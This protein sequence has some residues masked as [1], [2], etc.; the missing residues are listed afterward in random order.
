MSDHHIHRPI[1]LVVFFVIVV[2][3]NITYLDNVFP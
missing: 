2:V 1:V 3:T